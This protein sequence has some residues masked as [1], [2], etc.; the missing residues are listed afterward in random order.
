MFLLS[1]VAS[2]TSIQAASLFEKAE[3]DKYDYESDM[4]RICDNNFLDLEHLDS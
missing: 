1:K 4:N 2:R 3:I